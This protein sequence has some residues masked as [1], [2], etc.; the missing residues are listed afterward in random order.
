MALSNDQRALL[1]LLAQREEGYEDIAALLG[2]SVAEVRSRVKDALRELEASEAAS[3]TEEA[4]PPEPSPQPPESRPSPTGVA[5]RRG[6]P[7]AEETAEPDPSTRGKP[8]RQGPRRRW[9]DRRR[10]IEVVGGGLVILLL[11]LFATGAV[12]I[13]GDDDGGGSDGD[14]AAAPQSRQLTQ[15]RL[16]AVDGGDATGQAVF[17]RVRRQVVLVMAAEGLDPTPPAR[18]YAIVLARG[19]DDRIPI[20]A[21]QV[22]KD[23]RI[24]QQFKIAP[25]A[26][27]H[28]ASGYDEMQLVEVVNRQLRQAL[29][30]A[31]G[32]AVPK[33]SGTTVMSG[34]VTGPIV[35]AG[36]GGG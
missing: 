1:R 32:K 17:G 5:R 11:V 33:F 10:L 6:A 28:L 26:L 35:N 21:V 24:G 23:G 16:E 14:R 20:A 22:G 18:S 30:K 4:A 31:G 15:A 29:V 36:A 13:G 25:A 12:D 7:V 8:P 34:Q 9:P 27:G 2:L 19:P 3:Q